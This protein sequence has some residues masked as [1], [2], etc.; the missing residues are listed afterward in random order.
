MADTYTTAGKVRKIEDA[1]RSATWG[2]TLNSDTIE[3]LADFAGGIEEIDLG[4][5]TS[6][7]LAAL[8]NGT[9]SESRAAYIKFSGTPASAVTVTLHASIEK[10]LYFVINECGQ[11]L[12]VKYSTGTTVVLANGDR[13]FVWCTGSNVQ[14]VNGTYG[15]IALTASG[16]IPS[17][18]VTVR[19]SRTN[20]MVTLSVPSTFAA[21][22][23]TATHLTCTALPSYLWPALTQSSIAVSTRD[24]GTDQTSPGVAN[25]STSGVITVYRTWAGNGFTANSGSTGFANWSV[26][27]TV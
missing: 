7:S 8:S 18:S 16:P 6:H 11:T 4:T 21:G 19:W 23:I 5:A 3:L 17:T 14:S 12:T 24:N 9:D 2:P 22:N 1:T 13:T 20:G 10:K 26:S 25:I 27:Y 15:T